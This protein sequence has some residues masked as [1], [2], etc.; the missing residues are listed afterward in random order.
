M[1]KV[2]NVHKAFGS[3]KILKGV[4]LE[5]KKG[6]VVVI[7]GPSGSG[8]TTF[9]RCLDFMESADQGE[10]E[11][12]AIKTSL[13][14]AH[15]KTILDVRRKTGFVFQN[16]NLFNNKTALEN[17]MEGLVTARKIPKAKAKEIA[18]RALQKVGLLDRK[19]FYPSQL[20]GGQQQRVGIARAIAPNPDVVFFDEPTSALDPELVGEVLSA[21]KELAREGMTMIVVTHEMSFAEEVASQV[22]FMDGGVVV[23]K[24]TAKEIFNNPKE[25][26]TRQFLQ[27]TLKRVEYVI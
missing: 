14:H 2:T 1:L 16:F 23:E 5:V 22:V 3:N 26:R 24:G 17:V 10:M 20:S 8:K 27:R 4:D 15:K 11:F 21:I 6:D 12:D 19:D 13:R 18:E 9:L 25:E 7:L